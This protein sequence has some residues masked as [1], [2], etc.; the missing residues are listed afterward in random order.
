MSDRS[1]SQPSQHGKVVLNTRISQLVAFM[2]VSIISST[3][4]HAFTLGDLQG[5]AVLGQPLDVSVLVGVGDGEAV[6]NDCLSAEV[7]F[8]DIPQRAPSLRLQNQQAGALPTS[9]VRIRSFAAVNEPIVTVVL[10]AICGASTSRRYVLLSDFPVAYLPTIS[11]LPAAQ[12]A[13]VKTPSRRTLPPVVTDLP[14]LTASPAPASAAA[15]S[16][17]VPAKPKAAKS[18]R[19]IAAPT[20]KRAPALPPVREAPAPAV[21]ATGADKGRLVLKLDSQMLILNPEELAAQAALRVSLPKF[22]PEGEVLKQ[23]LQ[24]DALLN[25]LKVFKDLTRKNQATLAELQVKLSQSEAERIPMLWLY[26]LGGLLLAALGSLAWVLRQQQNAKA[27]WW[28]QVDDNGSPTEMIGP[29]T[30]IAP[31]ESATTASPMMVAPMPAMPTAP[32]VRV[33]PVVPEAQHAGLDFDLDQLSETPML[34]PDAAPLPV[35]RQNPPGITCDLNSET[36]TDLRQQ[37]EFF[38][39]L[40]QAP[41]AIHLLNRHIRESSEPRPTVYLDLLT[42]YHSQ[43][44]KAE[45]RELRHN[46]NRLFN[47]VIPDFSAYYQEGESLLDY[48]E[49]LAGLVRVWPN[50]DAIALLDACI[51]RSDLSAPHLGFDL[52]AFRDLLLLRTLVENVKGGEHNLQAQATLP[53]HLPVTQSVGLASQALPTTKE[54]ALDFPTDIFNTE[55]APK[56]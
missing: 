2:V 8:G 35:T 19:A 40:G 24:L 45:F 26:L 20:K 23:S 54:L 41:L 43:G 33:A 11:A 38:M 52:A 1:G 39:S 3:A 6:S 14:P 32:A 15:I 27:A 9:L 7:L 16:P 29:A 36:I 4:G 28:Q 49:P 37:A 55:K 12:P 51:F 5:S 13:G 22:E 34:P 53:A 31:A 46:F 50:L 17:R 10:R 21:T 56:S 42:L 47:A 30:D 44:M 25:D 18:T 48:P